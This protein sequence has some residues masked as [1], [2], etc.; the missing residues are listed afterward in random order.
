MHG[1]KV[2]QIIIYPGTKQLLVTD[3]AHIVL[4]LHLSEIQLSVVHEVLRLF[5]DKWVFSFIHF[6]IYGTSVL[7]SKT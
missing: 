2:N 5:V 6:T 3:T 4:I 1:N 7:V